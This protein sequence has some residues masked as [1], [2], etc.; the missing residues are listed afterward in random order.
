MNFLSSSGFPAISSS[1]S[2]SGLRNSQ[3]VIVT[4]SKASNLSKW[5]ITGIKSS[6][7][8]DA[9]ESFKIKLKGKSDLLVNPTLDEAF[10]QRL[11]QKKGSNACKANFDPLE[12][13]Y[14]N[15][16]YRVIDLAKL[17]LFLFGRSKLTKKAKVDDKAIRVAHILKVRRKKNSLS[18]VFRQYQP[19]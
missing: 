13:V 2:R 12:K 19:A 8:Y 4:R 5:I 16:C 6:K 3:K 14:C 1:S 17:I 11:K 9:R 10:Y 7:V 18:G 15:Q